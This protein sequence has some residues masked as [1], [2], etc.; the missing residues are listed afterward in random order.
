L[1]LADGQAAV[2]P[3]GDVGGKADLGSEW[4][5]RSG[6]NPSPDDQQSCTGSGHALIVTL[7]PR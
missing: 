3:S 5:Q 7:R 1:L 2:E 4:R 6:L